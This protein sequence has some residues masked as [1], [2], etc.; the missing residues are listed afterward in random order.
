MRRPWVLSFSYGRAL[1][2]AA[3]EAWAQGASAQEGVGVAEAQRLFTQQLQA[4][5]RATA[6]AAPAAA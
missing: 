1:T 5:S 3:M 6:H 2:A 4:A